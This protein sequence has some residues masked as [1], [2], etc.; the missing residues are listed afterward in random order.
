MAR[1]QMPRKQV[2]Q[3]NDQVKSPQL[4]DSERN[5]L[6]LL[7]ER[8]QVNDQVNAGQWQNFLPPRFLISIFVYLIH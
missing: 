6:S 3:V 5:V 1:V 4:A 7:K 2:D 8:D